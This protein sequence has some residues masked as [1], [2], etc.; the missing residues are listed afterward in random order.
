MVPINIRYSSTKLIF[1]RK[2]R[3]NINIKIKD[4]RRNFHGI[5]KCKNQ[6]HFQKCKRKLI[7]L[8][9]RE[10]TGEILKD[11]SNDLYSPNADPMEIKMNSDPNYNE[12]FLQFFHHMF[13]QTCFIFGNLLFNHLYFFANFRC[14]SFL[15]A[16]EQSF[17]Y[18]F[19]D[20][21]CKKN[22]RFN[23]LNISFSIYR[24]Y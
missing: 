14:F 19:M 1:Q 9:F 8:M 11:L 12:N 15:M 3:I 17:L 13:H 20:G 6:R 10:T 5:N 2:H 22:T 23:Q 18:R 16:L 21:A 7:L 4:I 24:L